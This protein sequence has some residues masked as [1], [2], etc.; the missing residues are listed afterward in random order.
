METSTVVSRIETTGPSD[1]YNLKIGGPT[2]L[3][4]VSGY[5]ASANVKPCLC[6][7]SS[8]TTSDLTSCTCVIDIPI[9]ICGEE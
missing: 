8:T 9:D 4:H 5:R 2:A 7:M 6:L 1:Q 3:K